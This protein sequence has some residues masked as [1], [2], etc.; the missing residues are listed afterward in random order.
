MEKLNFVKLEINKTIKG[1]I[2]GFGR[3]Q[4]GPFIVLSTDGKNEECIGISSIVLYNI[5][6]NNKSELRVGNTIEI[7]KLEKPRGK[8]YH[9]FDVKINGKNMYSS[10][11]FFSDKIDDLDE[12]FS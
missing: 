6:K 4:Y 11:V 12:L 10:G 3:T 7:T 5:I 1:I 9:L 8:R 2:K